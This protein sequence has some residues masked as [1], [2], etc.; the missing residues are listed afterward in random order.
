M[1]IVSHKK[2]ML[3]KGEQSMSMNGIDISNWQKGL[4]LGKISY[5]F[6]IIKATEGNHFVDEFCDGFYQKAKQMGK[7]LGVYHYANGLNPIEEAKF[8]LNNV[9]NYVGEAILV[10]DWEEIGNVSFRKNDFDWCKQWLDYVTKET[11]VK[12]M[13]YCQQSV[14]NK[15]K[16]VGD[17]GM[18]VAQYPDYI[19]TGY[20]ETPW[21]EGAY[22]CAMRQYS[23]VGRL[24]GYDGD[25]DLDKFYGDRTAWDKYTGKGNAV[26]PVPKPEPPKPVT[27]QGT[28]LDLVYKTMRGE[29][30][31]GET[32][33]KSLGTRYNEV[34][35][36][37]EYIYSASKEQLVKDVMA[38]RFGNDPVRSTVLGSRYKEV[39]DII[40][41]K[42][43]AVY[44]TVKPG[45]TLG[46]IAGRF[47][48]NYQN[49]A[50]IN[51]IANP[52]VI[53][54]GQKLRIK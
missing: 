23:S 41:G 3:E 16:G 42:G 7:C 35:N 24:D 15:F 27:P 10:L 52:D 51:G 45:D 8:F 18:W 28:K 50:R 31:D 2:I 19:P 4:D 49:I 17:Y 33:K 29:F 26:K 6:A 44:Y 30:G 43:Q 46:A 5:D 20:Q 25:L 1:D 36:E 37:I 53:Y 40:D 12:P 48:T 34:Q 39:Q 11:G 14:M 47:G 9:K 38:G 32:R 21:N 54:A 13:L 22:A